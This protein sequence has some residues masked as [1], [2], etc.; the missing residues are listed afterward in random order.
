MARTCTCIVCALALGIPACAHRTH[1]AK[2]APPVAGPNTDLELTPRNA[3][4]CA[5]GQHLAT[6]FDPSQQKLALSIDD[7]LYRLDQI[8][9]G[10]GAKFASADITFWSKGDDA[11]LEIAGVTTQCQRVASAP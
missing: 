1:Q 9:A 10:S 4:T 7:A 11:S 2:A 3:Y 6:Q 8:P 5:S